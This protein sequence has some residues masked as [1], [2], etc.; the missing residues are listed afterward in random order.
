MLK[1]RASAT[2]S[3]WAFRANHAQQLDLSRRHKVTFPTSPGTHKY[4]PIFF[5]QGRQV[6]QN[7][8]TLVLCLESRFEGLA[9]NPAPNGVG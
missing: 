7:A 6:D 9:A 8:L 1:N 4:R 2:P 5:G 3:V